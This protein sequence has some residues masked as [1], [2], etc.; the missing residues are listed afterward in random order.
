M[1][2]M[3]RREELR[4]RFVRA[5]RALFERLQ[6]SFN[7]RQ[8]QAIRAV[9]GPLLVLAG[10][11]SGKTTVLVERIAQIVRFGNAYEDEKTLLRHCPKRTW[12]ALSRAFPF[13]KRRSF[14][15]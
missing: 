6:E 3:E 12:C 13:Q 8:K 9:N 4:A 5:K 7:E 1:E 15:C 2:N 11:G 14:H 10:A